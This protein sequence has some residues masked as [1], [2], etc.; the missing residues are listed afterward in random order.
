MV[1]WVWLQA[2]STVCKLTCT[3]VPL[4]LYFQLKHLASSLIMSSSYTHKDSYMKD[5]VLEELLPTFWTRP[6][7]WP[8][9]V[10]EIVVPISQ[11]PQY[12]WWD[13]VPYS[14]KLLREKTFREFWG[15]V[16][17]RE[18]FLHKI[19]GVAFF[20]SDTSEQ[21]T[22]VSSAKIWFPPKCKS[23]LPRKL[24][25]IRYWPKCILCSVVLGRCMRFIDGSSIQRWGWHFLWCIWST[26]CAQ[27]CELPLVG[28]T[29]G[30][31]VLTVSGY[32]HMFGCDNTL[33]MDARDN[34]AGVS[35][36]QTS[37]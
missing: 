7:T 37:F 20:G 6:A 1:L 11:S 12:S 34:V 27:F 18:S 9:S 2:G 32:Y 16:A 10:H 29:F 15:F 31:T 23:F 13:M 3:G 28:S 5:G 14:G 35:H 36:G 22:K 4:P 24:P 19:G 33:G 8:H 30:S 21:S 25:T 26:L 17:I